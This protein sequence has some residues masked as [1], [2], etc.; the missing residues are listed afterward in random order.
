M[1][2]DSTPYSCL[3][4]STVLA[5]NSITLNQLERMLPRLYVTGAA[6]QSCSISEDNVQFVAPLTPQVHLQTLSLSGRERMKRMSDYL[7]TG[8]DNERQV[9]C[10]LTAVIRDLHPN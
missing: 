1:S 3:G 5:F 10:R 7:A 4:L 6:Q 2:A 9:A 8:L